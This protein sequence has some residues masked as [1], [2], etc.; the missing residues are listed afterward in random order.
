[1]LFLV[2]LLAGLEALRRIAAREHPEA[3]TGAIAASAR[4][5]VASMRRPPAQQPSASDEIERLAKLHDAGKLDDAEFAAA[6]ASVLAGSGPP[7]AS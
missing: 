2:L 5:A 3:Q 7:S 1:V 4:G 6:K